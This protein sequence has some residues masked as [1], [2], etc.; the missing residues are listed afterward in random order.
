MTAKK[1]IVPWKVIDMPFFDAPTI[2]VGID[3][4]GKKGSDEQVFSFVA[5]RE[6]TGH[7]Y[8]SQVK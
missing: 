4:I 6:M 8:T 5:S 7:A 3:S 1:G 2:C